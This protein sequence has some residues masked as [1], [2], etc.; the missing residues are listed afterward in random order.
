[1]NST[2]AIKKFAAQIETQVAHE[3]ITNFLGLHGRKFVGLEVVEVE[4]RSDHEDEVFA[5]VAYTYRTPYGQCRTITSDSVRVVAAQKAAV[6]KG[7]RTALKDRANLTTLNYVEDAAE[8]ALAYILETLGKQFGG[9]PFAAAHSTLGGA[10]GVKPNNV[11]ARQEVICTPVV[12]DGRT[13]M[14]EEVEEVEEVV[15][16]E[17]DVRAAKEAAAEISDDGDED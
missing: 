14:V 12:I 7:V 15:P 4:E 8:E 1:M 17:D 3:R 2:D 10:K 16:H 13:V 11:I 5:T 9:I 6:R